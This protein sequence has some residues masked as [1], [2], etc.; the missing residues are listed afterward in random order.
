MQRVG[1]APDMDTYYYI[2]RHYANSHNLEMCMHAFAD[3]TH[4]GIPL[5]L[6]T[7][8]IVIDLAASL[9]HPR[10]ALEI[11]YVFE[12]TVPRSLQASDWMNIL[13][14]STAVHFVR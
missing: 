14:A 8:Q 1:I 4:R 7:V 10:L 11:A 3:M 5:N 9:G 6:K 12:S 2:M 13:S